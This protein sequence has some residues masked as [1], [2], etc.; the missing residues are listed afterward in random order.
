MYRAFLQGNQSMNCPC[1][2][3]VMDTAGEPESCPQCGCRISMEIGGAADS[4]GK[5]EVLCPICRVRLLSARIEDEAARYCG[6]CGGFLADME[7]F[8]VIVDKRRSSHSA[9]AKCTAPFDP[10]ELKRVLTCPRCQRT[11]DTHPYFGGGN[12]V[13]TTCES[14][15]LIWLDAGKLALIGAYVPYVHQIERTLTLRGGRY[16]GGPDDVPSLGFLWDCYF[17]P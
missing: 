5:S 8:R 15:S 10:A 7:S 17:D 14:C 11:M 16:Q 3:S 6:Q 4:T 1:C 9:S 13:V 12:V 2:A